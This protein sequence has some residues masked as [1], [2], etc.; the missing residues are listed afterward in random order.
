[1]QVIEQ[2]QRVYILGLNVSQSIQT[3]ISDQGDVIAGLK[4]R[5][6]DGAE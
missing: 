1:V 5:G 6:T 3:G 2:Q 4:R